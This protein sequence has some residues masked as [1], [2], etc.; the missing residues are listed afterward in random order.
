MVGSYISLPAIGGEANVTFCYKKELPKNKIVI[1]PFQA[2]VVIFPDSIA[3][4]LS[5]K[6]GGL[7]GEDNFGFSLINSAR[8]GKRH[9]GA[10]GRLLSTPFILKIQKRRI[11]PELQNGTYL[12]APR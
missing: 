10:P 7:K 6:T 8:E 1:S 12:F 3:S 2:P 5:K 9:F 4:E 11:V